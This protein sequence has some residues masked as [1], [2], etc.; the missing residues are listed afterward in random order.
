[1]FRR[2]ITRRTFT[3]SSDTQEVDRAAQALLEGDGRPVAQD[4]LRLADVRPGI[5]DLAGPRV[6]VA[7]LHRAAEDA[8]DRLGELVHACGSAR[9]HVEDAAA[10]ALGLA[11]PQRCV[12]DVRHI[13]E[14][15]GLLAVP[16]DPDRLSARHCGDEQRHDGGV[17]RVRVLAWAEDVEVAQHDRLEA[18]IDPAE[19]DAVALRSALR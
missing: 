14:V 19:A 10:R 7:L 9:G 4:A 6:L 16:V 12:D 8:T 17:L 15:A 1:M 18:V 5:A 13:G 2:A 3:R 11:G